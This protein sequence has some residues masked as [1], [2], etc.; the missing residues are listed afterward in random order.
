MG[1]GTWTGAADKLADDAA[2]TAQYA[3]RIPDGDH[4][5]ALFQ[6]DWDGGALNLQLPVKVIA[7]VQLA[8]TAEVGDW[9]WKTGDA[10]TVDFTVT[11]NESRALENVTLTLPGAY[12]CGERL[13]D[14][15]FLRKDRR[16]L[17]SAQQTDTFLIEALEPGESVTMTAQWVPE[18]DLSAVGDASLA[19]Q[20]EVTLD[21]RAQAVSAVHAAQREIL[22]PGRWTAMLAGGVSMGHVLCTLA[23]LTA[24]VALLAACRARKFR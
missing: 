20:A 23:G 11:N 13:G 12:S 10:H 5:R 17:K 9:S 4:D 8:V 1:E 16:K 15:T 21:G 2:L 6:L 18:G 19:L 24:L 22:R 3:V 14:A 7:P